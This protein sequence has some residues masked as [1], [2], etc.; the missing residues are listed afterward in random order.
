MPLIEKQGVGSS[1]LP[2]ATKMLKKINQLLINYSTFFFIRKKLF[3]A[4]N[5]ANHVEKKYSQLFNSIEQLIKL[6]L[7]S[8]IYKFVWSNKEKVNLNL[9][10]I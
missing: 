3:R 4:F 6:D 10:K 7:D 2:L 1:I 5:R 8:E 9:I